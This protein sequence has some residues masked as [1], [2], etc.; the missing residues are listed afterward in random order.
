M[1]GANR[2]TATLLLTVLGLPVCLAAVTQADQYSQT[3][4]TLDSS[5]PESVCQAR[6]AL[7][8]ILSPNLAE[9]AE[10]FRSF[11]AFF[12]HAIATTGPAFFRRH[13]SLHQ[14]L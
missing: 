2:S 9:N 12:L 8:K 5:Q 6:E 10:P 14:R 1:P 11:R 3:L 13:E 7:Q 4:N